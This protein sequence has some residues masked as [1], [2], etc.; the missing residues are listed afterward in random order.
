MTSDT[1]RVWF[2]PEET[3]FFY[4]LIPYSQTHG[5][6]G[7]IAQEEKKGI[8]ALKRFLDKKG[9]VPL[10][11]QSAFIPL[12]VRWSAIYRKI[13]GGHV[14]LVGDAA[15]HVKAS[16]VGGIV[17]GLRGALGVAEAILNGGTSRELRTLNRELDMHWLIRRSLHGFDQRDY[18]R[19]LDMLNP[20]SRRLL[21]VLTRDETVKLLFHLL[22]RQPRLLLLGLKSLISS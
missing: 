12:Y 16:T 17:T 9:L 21:S 4:W 20:A 3:P 10:D 1:T 14:Y 13:G 19:L 2:L 7:M 15:G 8:A 6:L 5:V 22:L 11:F 18:V